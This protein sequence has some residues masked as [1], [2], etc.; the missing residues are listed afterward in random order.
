LWNHGTRCEKINREKNRMIKY[1]VLLGDFIRLRVLHWEMTS[2][3]AYCHPIG[4]SAPKR[5]PGVSPPLQWDGLTSG[6]Q[7]TFPA[8]CG[9]MGNGEPTP[10]RRGGGEFDRNVQLSMGTSVARGGG[11]LCGRPVLVKSDSRGKTTASD[12][13]EKPRGEIIRTA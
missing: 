9:I 6:R 12:A 7:Q 2:S 13:Y 4:P 8:P 5:G 11:L 1:I 3:P 10:A